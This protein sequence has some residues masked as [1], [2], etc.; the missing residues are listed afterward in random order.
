[1]AKSRMFP[2]STEPVAHMQRNPGETFQG[3]AKLTGVNVPASEIELRRP[4]PDK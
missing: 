2:D 1:M 3:M 4:Q